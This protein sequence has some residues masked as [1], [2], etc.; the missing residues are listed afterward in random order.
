MDR[1]AAI[2]A[3]HEEEHGVFTAEEIEAARRELFGEAQVEDAGGV[4][5][6]VRVPALTRHPSSS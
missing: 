4:G 1:L 3:S 2:V 6:S 5:A